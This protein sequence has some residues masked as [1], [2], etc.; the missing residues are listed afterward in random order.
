MRHNSIPTKASTRESQVIK[1]K[2][3]FSAN[4]SVQ[5]YWQE[6]KNY[7]QGQMPDSLYQTMIEVL[8]TKPSTDSNSDQ[9]EL[10]APS[11]QIASRISQHY[12][13]M[14]Q[15]F[16]LKSTPFQGQLRL[17]VRQKR[18]TSFK[19]LEDNSSARRPEE[20]NGLQPFTNS[21]DLFPIAPK[22]NKKT[23]SRKLNFSSILEEENFCIPETNWSQVE[24]LLETRESLHYIY[25]SE[26]SGKSTI[27]KILKQTREKLGMRSRMLRFQDFVS[28]LAIAAHK[29]DTLSWN[30]RL[31]SYDCLVIDDFQY[32][33]P[34]AL[35]SQ[36]ELSY[37]ID[38]FIQKKK[39]L[40]FCSDR[41]VQALPLNPSL[42]SRL[43]AGAI[44]HLAYP[45]QKER[46]KILKQET[47]KRNLLLKTE[48]IQN[49]ASSICRDMRRLKTAVKR[50]DDEFYAEE[51][52]KEKKT[53]P[54]DLASLDRLC[55][56]LYSLSPQ[57]KP[58]DILRAVANFYRVSP[59]S[60]QG[61]ARDKKYS[62]ARHL[63]AYLC[64]HK[65]K[66]KQKETAQLIGRS[67]HSSVIYAREKITKTMERDLFFRKQVQDICRDLSL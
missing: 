11:K 58:R 4:I 9:L 46:E 42:I 26:G 63:T 22:K 39:T 8:S 13:P 45:N 38:E 56:D 61:P 32:I 34:Q 7:L 67:D 36:E 49:L 12:L 57:I 35:R 2:T 23:P 40:I 25:G 1:S 15:D 16:L 54:L 60:I 55:G 53:L 51:A 24:R 30:K 28:E 5:K 64:T 52:M 41:P 62:S 31:R 17:Q 14:I 66:M 48:L 43:Q 47:K 18:N 50:L 33:K 3:E 65:L 21:R 6:C 27:G 10:F 59:E 37:L 20:K 29:R 44:I 19:N